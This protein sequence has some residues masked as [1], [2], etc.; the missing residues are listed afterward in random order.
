MGVSAQEGHP[1]LVR[2]NL[3]S[4]G[5]RHSERVETSEYRRCTALLL[6]YL[7]L[8]LNLIWEKTPV[9]PGRIRKGTLS[10]IGHLY[11]LWITFFPWLKSNRLFTIF[12]SFLKNKYSLTLSKRRLKTGPQKRR[13]PKNPAGTWYANPPFNVNTTQKRAVFATRSRIFPE[14]LVRDARCFDRVRE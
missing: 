4:S 6:N 9:T 12:S 8:I 13:A 14:Y 7:N 5:S 10:C 11:D 3:N 1:Y 2:R